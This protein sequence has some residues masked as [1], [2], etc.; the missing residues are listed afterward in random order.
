ML[1]LTDRQFTAPMLR[2]M[3]QPRAA[4]NCSSRGDATEPPAAAAAL[5]AR[6]TIASNENIAD[7]NQIDRS[8]RNWFRRTAVSFRIQSGMLR[9]SPV[10]RTRY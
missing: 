5:F 6:R 4:R 9:R 2:A 8:A 1:T 10:E 7:T 3:K